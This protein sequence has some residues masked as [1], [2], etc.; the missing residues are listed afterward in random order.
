MSKTNGVA[1]I[2]HDVETAESIFTEEFTDKINGL[3]RAAF[4]A[5]VSTM[6]SNYSQSNEADER[7]LLDEYLT[8]IEDV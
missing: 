8:A 2:I 7:D 3:S 6:F 5:F 1:K 4:F